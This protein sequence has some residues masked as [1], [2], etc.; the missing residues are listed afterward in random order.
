MIELGPFARPGRF[1]RGNLHTHST[2]SDGHLSPEAI[3]ALY[4]DAG[5]D[6]LA[7]SDHFLERYGYP[8]TDAS[9]FETD[10]F[11]TL[12]AAELHAGRI[13]T[14]E[15]W[16]LLGV[17]LPADFAPP[18]VDESGRGLAARALAGGAF[19]AALHPAWYGAT[20]A[21]IEALGPIHAVEIW[22][23]TCADLNDR[24]DSRYV[25]DGLLA[26]GGRY[27]ALASDDAHFT[28]ERNDALQAW[29]WVKSEALEP[30]SLV[31]A[32]KAGDYYTSTGPE[33]GA[34]RIESSGQLVVRS[35][36]VEWIFANG[37]GPQ[38]A[39]AHG[40]ELTEVA[41]DIGDFDSPFWQITVRDGA[42][43]RAWSNPIWMPNSLHEDGPGGAR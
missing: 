33:I 40:Q 16:H 39:S 34:I 26:R 17:G 42:G 19:V 43:R 31:V 3:C 11:V 4:R 15:F 9:V 20:V 25:L 24:P 12:R 1:W 38:V 23:A 36:P 5:Y 14:G 28:G 32:L 6:F 13:E 30:D 22:N 35:S 2:L 37:R 21:E 7:I 41:L 27:F 18:A 29:V 10:G 8:L